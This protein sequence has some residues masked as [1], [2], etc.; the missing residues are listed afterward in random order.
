MTKEEMV[1]SLITNEATNWKEDDKEL[2]M[3]TDDDVLA[4]MMPVIKNEEKNEEGVQNDGQ[5][6]TVD[7]F[8]SKAPAEMQEVLKNG[9]NT[10]N[11]EKKKV[12]STITAFQAN[13][14]TEKEL[15]LKDLDELKKLAS[16]IPAPKSTNRYDGQ[17]DSGIQNNAHVEEPLIMPTMNFEKK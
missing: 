17:A 15:Q 12:I 3:Q 6:A 1:N 10:Y 2:L 5:P 16:F 8:I 7:E 11:T 9:I 13:K 14:F 4:K